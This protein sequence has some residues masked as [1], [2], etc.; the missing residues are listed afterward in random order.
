[1]KVVALSKLRGLK[2][3]ELAALAGISLS[4]AQLVIVKAIEGVPLSSRHERRMFRKL[5]GCSWPAGANPDG[6]REVLL[7][8]GRRSGKSTRVAVLLAASAMLATAYEA[9]LAHGEVAKALLTAPLR[10]QCVILLDALEGLFAQLGIPT[11]RLVSSLRVPGLRCIAEIATCDNLASRSGTSVVVIQDEAGFIPTDPAAAGNDRAVDGST[12]PSLATTRGRFVK[13]GTANGRDGLFYN[14]TE[15]LRG[16]VSTN[17]IGFIAPTWTMNPHITEAETH[18]LEP[19]ERTWRREYAAEP[20]DAEESAFDSTDVLSCV[21]RH[22][23]VRRPEPGTAYAAGYDASGG[24]NDAHGLVIVHRE[25]IAREGAPPFERFVVD[26]VK[27]WAPSL[28]S[29][30]DFDRVMREVATTADAYGKAK[31]HRDNYAGD[32]V[33]SALRAHG[34]R[35]VGVSMTAPAQAERFARLQS[36]IQTGRLVLPN[37]ADLVREL[38]ALRQ[39]MHSGGRVTFAAP[40]R[41]SAHDDLVDAL[42]LAVDAARTLNPSGDI[43]R[44]FV[45]YAGADGRY[46]GIESRFYRIVRDPRTG[47]ENRVPC[48]PPQGTPEFETYARDMLAR[49]MSSPAIESWQRERQQTH[50][51]LNV[52][53]TN[54][55]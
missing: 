18:A 4:L 14:R 9:A 21:D 36:L 20:T 27:R 45:P 11:Q 13:I 19:D 16:N 35:S 1:V 51:E 39:R 22:V 5:T 54:Q 53:V 44:E 29:R 26:C 40:N 6:Y 23:S 50:R 32:A 28:L 34:A 37:H 41:K 24:R 49:G 52:R 30:P 7:R 48:E 10:S 17:A 8:C 3:H 42:A 25:L 33:E 15:E 2:A 47:S 31:I 38:C 12:R 55:G 46:G 43:A